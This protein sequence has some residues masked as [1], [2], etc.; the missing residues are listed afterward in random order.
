MRHVAHIREDQ[1]EQ[2]LS[3]HLKGTA[4]GR[5]TL[6]KYLMPAKRHTASVWSTIRESTVK[7]FRSISAERESVQITP[8]PEPRPCSHRRILPAPL[9]WPGH[10][11]GLPDGGAKGDTEGPTLMGR[12]KKKVFPCP[13]FHREISLP[14]FLPDGRVKGDPFAQSVYIR[15]LFSCLVD[16][17]FLDTEWFMKDG[18][19]DRGDY[20]SFDFFWECL[21][22][23][24]KNKVRANSKILPR[25]NR[26]LNSLRNE[27][28]DACVKG[29]EQ[30]PGLF[31][32]TVP[33][34]G[35]KTLSSLAFALR[36]ALCHGLTRIIY[37]IPYT[38]I[39]EQTAQVF[40][41]IVGE[42]NVLEH[43]SQ[44]VADSGEDSP[45]AVRRR[46]A[47]ENWDA[48]IVVTTNVQFFES[49][50]DNRPSRC[51]KV[52]RMANS[53]IIFD[54]VQE[55]PPPHLIPCLKA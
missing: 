16:A 55:L 45:E 20:G 30:S 9:R 35:G 51:R 2:L 24:H 39:I 15:M 53:V 3:E 40:R 19:V 48:P 13:D 27:I 42:Q 54:E 23:D 18:Q 31:T 11:G 21:H 38:S 43:H 47:S 17:D 44:A 29:A 33:T 5:R 1:S 50:Y 7:N 22:R 49:F 14:D 37:V 12:M 6:R 46:L 34:G 26:W 10:H 25:R 8:R 52:H 36:H 41:D 32:L 28:Y 4:G